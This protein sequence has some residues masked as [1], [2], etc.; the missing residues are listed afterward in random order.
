MGV[1]V[2]DAKRWTDYTAWFDSYANYV[3]AFDLS[4]RCCQIYEEKPRPY[5][6]DFLNNM[7]YYMAE[8]NNINVGS[9]VMIL[10]AFMA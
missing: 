8:N 6:Q 1:S 3:K 2:G 4:F 5:D 9:F 10:K 7:S